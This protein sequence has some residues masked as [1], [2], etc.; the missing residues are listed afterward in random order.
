[1]LEL[2]A[3]AEAM[4]KSFGVI[5]SFKGYRGYP[6]VLC[7]NVNEQVVHGIPTGYVLKEGD[8]ITVDCGVVLDG[9]HTD[10]AIQKG[11]GKVD[12][13]SF[14]LMQTAEKALEKGIAAVKPGVRIRTISGIIQDIVEKNGFSV[15]RDL[16]G[17][18]VGK[19]LHEDPPVPN[20]RD[21]DHGPML[22]P[23]MTIA[24]EPII[25]MGSDQIKL[26]KDGWTYVTA[27]G[28]RATQVEHS[29]AVTEKGAEILTKRGQ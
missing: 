24:I 23:G 28:S 2:D 16:I 29:I 17:H 25:S 6:N 12:E 9:F 8:I 7:A 26:M 21:E 1:T 22:Q 13:R 27:D 4:M 11:V 20:F 18:G 14:K 3:K 15:V 10:S 5:P 19:R